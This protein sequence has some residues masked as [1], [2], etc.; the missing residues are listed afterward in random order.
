MR[1]NVYRNI[2]SK[3][4]VLSIRCAASGLVLGHALH[5][6]LLD[7]RFVI[8]SSGQSQVRKSHQKNVHAWVSGNLEYLTDFTS[9]KGRELEDNVLHIREEEGALVREVTEDSPKVFKPIQYDPYIDDSF[10]LKGTQIEVQTAESVS[11]YC[12]G[13][14]YAREPKS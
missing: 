13:A 1:V 9:I 10:T 11:I 7:C 14:I 3:P 4:N 8:Q 6:D 2:K 12:D 5:A